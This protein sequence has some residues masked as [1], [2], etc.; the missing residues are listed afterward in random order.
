MIYD[1][2]AINIYDCKIEYYPAI[3]IT[4]IAVFAT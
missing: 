1:N 3:I 2:V 4:S